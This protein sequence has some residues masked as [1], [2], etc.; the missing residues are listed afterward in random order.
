MTAI[1][2]VKVINSTNNM[3]CHD[4][5]ATLLSNSVS[6]NSPGSWGDFPQVAYTVSF[7]KVAFYRASEE[8][9][10]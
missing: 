7:P 10:N 1:N 2:L 4:L 8:K 9:L 3:H 6:S 5:R